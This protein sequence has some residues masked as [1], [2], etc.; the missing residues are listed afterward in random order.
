MTDTATRLARPIQRRVDAYFAG[1]GQGMN[2]HAEIRARQDE[3]ERLFEK[4]D[5]Q[6]AAMGLT[7]DGIPHHVF[8]DR[9]WV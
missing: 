9:F 1:M 6:L 2:A 5:S 4:S 3:L 8:L 7:R